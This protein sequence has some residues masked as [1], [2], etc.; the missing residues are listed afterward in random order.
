[1]MFEVAPVFVVGAT[2]LLG[3]RIV[4]DLLDRGQPVRALVRPGIST[5]KRNGLAGLE[6]RGLE[7][8][9]GDITD[10]TEK[11]VPALDGAS[12]VI[13][14]VQGGPDL[15]VDGQVNLLRA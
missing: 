10:P 9:A 6:A 2:G 3:S 11:L 14:A 7:I 8:V 4:D 13:S 12:T 5:E 15:I 1:M